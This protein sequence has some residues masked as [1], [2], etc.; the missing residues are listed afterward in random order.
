MAPTILIIGATGN[1]GKS[2][3][4]TLPKLL[5]SSKTG[6]RILAL[7]RSLDNPASQK[8]TKLSNVE[9]QEKDWTTIDADWL[10][11]Q[12][13]VKVFIA[14]HNE[15]NQFV[16]ESALYIALLNAGV[17]YV[18]RVSTFVG[19]VGPTS[20][21]FYGRTHW[22]IENLLSQP[23]FKSLQWTSLQPN[24]F[25]SF[26]LA[27]A[28]NWIKQYQKTGTQETLA[29]F[30]SADVPVAMIDPD[31]VGTAGAHLLALEDPTPHNQARYILNGPEDVTGKQIIE[32]V[33][34]LTGV[35]VQDVQFKDVSFLEHS[36]KTGVY[37][38]KLLPSTLR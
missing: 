2:V 14:S 15:T 11:S 12:E 27:S 6:Y 13:V 8:L 32:A 37:P 23:E 36:F 31:D 21:V 33:E 20:G 10:K 17:K 16:E 18:V 34:Q 26:A 25:T 5:E 22:A 19:S 3:V 9:I 7:T 35:K 4:H 1:T 29:T 30:M 24:L 28:A 38:S